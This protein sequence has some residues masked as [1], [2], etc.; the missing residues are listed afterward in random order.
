M[1]LETYL[2]KLEQLSPSAPSHGPL[3]RIS[4]IFYTVNFWLNY[5]SLAFDAEANFL[6]SVFVQSHLF[7]SNI[8]LIFFLIF[9]DSCNRC[10]IFKRHLSAYNYVL[11][12]LLLGLTEIGPNEDNFTISALSSLAMRYDPSCEIT[13]ITLLKNALCQIGLILS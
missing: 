6:R 13:W 3:W 7:N 12:C 8:S 5:S 10:V 2:I 11:E 4:S 9:E 1:Q